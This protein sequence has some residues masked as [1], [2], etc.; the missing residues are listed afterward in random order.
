[1]V[2]QYPCGWFGS[3]N[4]FIDVALV[5]LIHQLTEHHHRCMLEQPANSQIRAWESSAK[6]LQDSFNVLVKENTGIETICIIFEYELPRERGRRPDVILLT[7]NKAIVIEFK[8]AQY[9]SQAYV[10]QV[11]AYSRDLFNY[12]AASHNLD[13][14]SIVVLTQAVQLNSNIDE[15]NVVSPDVMVELLRSILSSNHETPDLQNWINSEY[16]P[17]PTIVSA[18]RMLFQHEPLPNIRRAQSAGIPQTLETLVN[19]AKQAENKGE[20]HLAILTGVPGSGKTLAGL[21]LVYSDRVATEDVRNNAVFLSGNGP[22]VEVFQ[23]ALKNKVFVQDVHGFL[24]QYGGNSS[25][26]PTEHIWIYDEAQRAWD[27]NRSKEKR[28]KKVSEPEDF[29]KIAVRNDDWRFMVGLVGEGQE[30]HVGEEGG[31]PQWNDAI[32]K[33]GGKW[34]VH[35]PPKLKET[36]TS[37]SNVILHDEL[38]LTVS[39]RSHLA[40]D[41]QDWVSNLL[42][43]D[44][45]IA[46]ALSQYLED[47]GFDIY[48]TQDLDQ[49]KDYVRKRYLDQFDKKYGLIASSKAQD[50]EYYGIHND[51]FSTRKVQYGPWY[52]NDLT[53]KRSCCSL[54]Q[55]VT[56]FGCQGLELDFPIVCWGSDLMWGGDRWRTPTIK[57]QNALNP[58]VLRINSYRVLLTRGRDGFIVFVPDAPRYESTVTVLKLAGLKELNALYNSYL[59]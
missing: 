32:E 19:I 59:D 4:N 5:D 16:D 21:Q 30:I 1:M 14:R 57:R 48:I 52:N 33:T 31:L 25:Q 55:V 44:L 3:V 38:D 51:Y 42:D 8:E 56:E 40:E 54:E 47:Q 9:R 53:D 6:I 2:I 37:T 10:D 49:A 39:L 22:L 11:I 50:L 26:M 41:V 43:G 29:L 15:V 28:G 12:H 13:F 36:F 27:A 58:H 24:K 17:L 7:Q 20:Q 18:A 46:K 34:I 45:K 35:C 23:H